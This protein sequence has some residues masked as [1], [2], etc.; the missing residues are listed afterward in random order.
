MKHSNFLIRAL[1]FSILVPVFCTSGE[2]SLSPRDR[3]R[4]RLY[5]ESSLCYGVLSFITGVF[6]LPL[7]T[8]TYRNY[9]DSLKKSDGTFLRHLSKENMRIKIGCSSVAALLTLSLAYKSHEAYEN[10]KKVSSI[11]K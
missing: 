11:N 6:S 2:T 4:A 1:F 5:A 3:R 7:I 8:E 9:V 10:S